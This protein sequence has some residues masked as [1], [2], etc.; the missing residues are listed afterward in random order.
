MHRVKTPLE[1]CF[2]MALCGAV[3]GAVNAFLCFARIPVAVPDNPSFRWVVVPGGMLH[4]A[5]LALI[6]V[7]AAVAMKC[8]PSW[9]KLVLAPVLAWVA[10][11]LSWIPLS[12]WAADETW[13][14]SL[15]WP[16]RHVSFDTIWWPFCH[17]G[18]VSII[19]F[20]CL[21][22]G[23]VKRHMKWH[24]AYGVSAGVLGS[25]WWWTLWHRWYFALIHGAI[26]GI[27]VGLA[28]YK[29]EKTDLGAKDD[30]A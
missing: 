21:S 18:L 16:F 28:A 24:V 4:G 19:Y 15:V 3:G 12:R 29:V 10:G 6:P 2:M 30:V 25:L 23:G 5:V 20:L 22:L 26:W 11:Y 1:K 14:R 17:F 8:R 27:L 7:L 9:V 13:S